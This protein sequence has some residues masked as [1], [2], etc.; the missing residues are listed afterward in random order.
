MS[1]DLRSLSLQELKRF[2]A[3]WPT[4]RKNRI[5]A[6]KSFFSFLRE[7][8]ATL[9]SAQ[10]ETLALKV[11]PSRPERGKSSPSPVTT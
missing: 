3:R 1:R 10:D 2:L 4:A 6:I 9:P 11:P 5:I 8:S 7:V